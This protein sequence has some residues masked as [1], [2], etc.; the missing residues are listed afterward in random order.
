VC[1]VCVKCVCVSVCV[2]VRVCVCELL[3]CVLVGSVRVTNCA[4]CDSVCVCACVCV[5]VFVCVC[6]SL[7]MQ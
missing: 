5:C 7:R 6:M 3:V 1:E 4:P 2:C